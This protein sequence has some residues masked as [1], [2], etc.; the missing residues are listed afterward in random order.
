MADALIDPV[1]AS[2]RRPPNPLRELSEQDVLDAVFHSGPLT[3]PQIA[4]ETNLSKATVG[5]AID[6]LERAGIVQSVGRLRGARGRSP[7]A[8]AVRDTAGF[9]L[10]IDIGGSNVRVGAADIFG[11]LIHDERHRTT[12]EGARAVSTQVVEIASGVI[13]RARSTH[14]RVLAVG[15]STPGVVDQ[16]TQ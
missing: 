7:V 2:R 6:R 1:D 4:A 14:E 16:R 3:R 13:D 12:H 15:I 11:E 10:G 9:V 8:Y 5:A